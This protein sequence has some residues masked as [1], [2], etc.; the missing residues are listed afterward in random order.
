MNFKAKFLIDHSHKNII[1]IEDSDSS[2]N[3]SINIHNVGSDVIDNFDSIVKHHSVG[4]A[5]ALP[6]IVY[7][8]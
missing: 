1:N 7:R 4:D 2:K 5:G 6:S 8:S 3:S